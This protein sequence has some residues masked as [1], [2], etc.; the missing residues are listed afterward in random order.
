[1]SQLVIPDH[2]EAKTLTQSMSSPLSVVGGPQNDRH[3]YDEVD[4]TV[5]ECD[6]WPVLCEVVH[7]FDLADLQR[8]RGAHKRGGDGEW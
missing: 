8:Q 7:M 4:R 3:W 2:Q 6:T 1:M 5:V